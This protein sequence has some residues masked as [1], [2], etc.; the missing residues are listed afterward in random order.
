MKIVIQALLV[1]LFLPPFLIALFSYTLKF[2]LLNYTFWQETLTKNN[3]YTDL[4]ANTKTSFDNQIAKE[5]GN[6]NDIK[7]LT[8][9][10][11]PDNTK[12]F[13][14]KNIQNVLNFANGLTPQINI[15][16]PVNKVPKDLMPKD[17][18]D[19]KP[20]MTLYDLLTKFNFQDYQSL[21]LENLANL[22]KESGYIFAGSVIIALLVM[23]LFFSLA[24]D[25]KMLIGGGLAFIFSGGL[26]LLLVKAGGAL[27]VD[28]INRRVA[29]TSI[30]SVIFETIFPPVINQ[31]ILTW[32]T[33]G[34]V[35]I[36]VGIILFLIKKPRLGKN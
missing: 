31:I 11:T 34:I 5:G 22:G 6:K 27:S 18:S 13:L 12:D 25:G 24:G 15:Y 10:I 1:I 8:D 36:V 16:L 3:V 30:T 29:S 32:Q 19:L 14:D 28:L 33:I 9:L 26:T 7:V 17:L 35:L 23:V 20:Q 2:Q 21:H 4:A